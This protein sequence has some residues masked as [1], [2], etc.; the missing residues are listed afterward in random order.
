MIGVHSIPSSGGHDSVKV[1]RANLESMRLKT[2]LYSLFFP[3]SFAFA[4][5]ALAAAASLALIAGLL[6]RSFL[7]GLG[8]ALAPFNLAQRIF[9]ALTRAF[10]SLRR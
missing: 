1:A 10:T 2:F 9:R 6:R 7:A 5:L 4:H 8:A 3:S